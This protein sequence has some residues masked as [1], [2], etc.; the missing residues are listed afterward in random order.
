LSLPGHLQVAETFHFTVRSA[1]ASL[2]YCSETG[3]CGLAGYKQMQR[4][5]VSVVGFEVFNDAF[6][7]QSFSA[8]WYD[9]CVLSKR[10][11]LKKAIVDYL[12]WAGHVARMGEVMGAYNILVG[13]PGGRNH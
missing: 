6:Q 5:C 7:L 3:K 4:K 1:V 11:D 2:F 10:M 12:R 8:E 13:R 9:E